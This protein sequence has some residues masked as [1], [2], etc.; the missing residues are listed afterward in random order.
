MQL[1][2]GSPSAKKAN[3]CVRPKSEPSPSVV[4]L[5]ISAT[6]NNNPVSDAGARAH[7]SYSLGVSSRV[8]KSQTDARASTAPPRGHRR[9]Q[10]R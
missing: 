5:F 8:Q 4:C 6:R 2:S 3:R 1:V 9:R 10:R 7:E